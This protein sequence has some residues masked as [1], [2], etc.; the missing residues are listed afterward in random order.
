MINKP[1][2]LLVAAAAVVV[3]ALLVVMWVLGSITDRDLVDIGLKTG[4]VL[5]VVLVA[6]LVIGMLSKPKATK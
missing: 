4:L 5:L 3:A 6:G 1:F 2:M